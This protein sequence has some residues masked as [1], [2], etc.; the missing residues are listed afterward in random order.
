MT[1]ENK[2]PCSCSQLVKLAV[3][4]IW[5]IEFS[6]E[7]LRFQLQS[8]GKIDETQGH[9]AFRYCPFCGDE[10]SDDFSSGDLEDKL[11]RAEDVLSKIEPLG[12]VD[13]IRGVLG[14]PSR[15]IE[16]KE[17]GDEAQQDVKQLVF[18]QE[19][20]DVWVIITDGEHEITITI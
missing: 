19:D 3:S 10:I 17:S 20:F 6:S 18:E 16:T 1:A 5:P 15:V 2:H 11:Q 13:D 12:S 7:S 4:N 9:L 8:V 14:E